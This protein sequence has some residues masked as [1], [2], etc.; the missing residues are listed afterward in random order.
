MTKAPK[1]I[2]KNPAQ[3]AEQIKK[4][5]SPQKQVCEKNLLPQPEFSLLCTAFTKGQIDTLIEGLKE[6]G[7]LQYIFAGRSNVG[8]SSLINALARRKNLAKTSSTPGKTRSVNAYTVI[9]PAAKDPDSPINKSPE[10]FCLVDLPGY[11]YARCSHKEREHWAKLIDYYLEKAPNLV[12]MVLLLDCR[13]PPQES[14]TQLALYALDK[15]IPLLPV[16]TKADKCTARER[17]A[18]KEQWKLILDGLSPQLVSVK[19]THMIGNLWRTLF[20]RL[21]DFAAKTD[22]NSGN[23]DA[24]EEQEDDF[25]KES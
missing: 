10:S 15:K 14:D 21:T 25:A 5:S 6:E 4:E 3:K 7:S 22:L 2:K 16:L 12:G 20:E 19:D 17:K 8:K 23:T 1:K 9:R 13:I 11:G 18:K 24:K